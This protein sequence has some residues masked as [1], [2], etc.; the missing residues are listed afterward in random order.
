MNTYK[1]ETVHTKASEAVHVAATSR[2]NAV[3][4]AFNEMSDRG[5]TVVSMHE[6]SL[7]DEK[8]ETWHVIPDHRELSRAV[9]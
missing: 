1:V 3:Y 9:A 8:T 7:Y 4:E 5:Y 2:E 6:V